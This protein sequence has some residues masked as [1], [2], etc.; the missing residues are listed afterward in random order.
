VKKAYDELEALGFIETQRG[1]GTFVSARR[2]HA[3]RGARLRQVQQASRQL[4]SQAY[5]AGLGFREVMKALQEA[6]RELT[7]GPEPRPSKEPR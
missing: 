3:D 6:D 1:R 7:R 5:L 2:P 4:L